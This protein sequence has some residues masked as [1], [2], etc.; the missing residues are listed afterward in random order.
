[1]Q[2]WYNGYILFR[3]K[4]NEFVCVVIDFRQRKYLNCPMTMSFEIRFLINQYFKAK[5][6]P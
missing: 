5:T 6:C 1:M 3:L 2:I 4:V